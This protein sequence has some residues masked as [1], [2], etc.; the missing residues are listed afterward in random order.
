MTTTTASSSSSFSSSTGWLLLGL[1]LV[2]LSN[3]VGFTAPAVVLPQIHAALGGTPVQLNWVTNAF[4]L[5]FGGTLMAAGALADAHGRRLLFAGGGLLA[6]L[7]AWAQTVAQ[8][9]TPGI[10]A[11]DVLRALQGL[12]CAAGFAGGTAALAQ[13]VHGAAQ[14]RAFSWIGTSFGIGLALGPIAAGALADLWGWRAAVQLPAAI[15]LPGLVIGAAHMPESRNPGAAGLDVPGALA[16]TLALALLTLGVLQAPESG[17]GH[18]LAWGALL[19]ATL[20]GA[21]FTVLELRALRAG[22]QP[23]L[24]LSLLRY[25][26]FVGVQMLAAAPAF[27]YVVLLVLLP[28]R[29]V[30]IDGR[31]A[32]ET[33]Q[34]MLLLSAPVIV[35]PGLAARLAR[36]HSA[37]AI[38]AF[39][40]LLSA[41]GLAWLAQAQ[42]HPP[43]RALAGPLL[44]IGA[45]IGLPWGLMDGLAVSVVPRERAGMAVGIFN[46]VRVAGEGIALA[47]VTLALGAFIAQRL[48]RLPGVAHAAAHAA[49]QRLAVGDLAQALERL[50]GTARADVL[51]A[52]ASALSALL[53]TLAGVTLAVAALIYLMLR[54]RHA[55]HADEAAPS[56]A[57][58]ECARKC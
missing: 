13:Q 18:P 47:L 49:A 15:A 26:R 19:C 9:F 52:Y 5:L 24:D 54:G 11:F 43:V 17:W 53:H 14:L 41:A 35:V 46:T 10:V 20:A 8:V 44:L 36:R 45:G 6:V 21:L 16:F 50:P 37:G 27:A 58:P 51:A 7:S 42:G 56:G 28:V 23:M 31:G 48:V 4:M 33:G 1:C 29:F 38:S 3:P 34:L 55:Q 2:C 12:G 40:L 32:L 22:R 39:G 57:H 25:P 30:G